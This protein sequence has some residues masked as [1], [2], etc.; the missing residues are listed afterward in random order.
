MASLKEGTTGSRT[1]PLIN[2]CWEYIKNSVNR[3]QFFWFLEY[4]LFTLYIFITYQ[5]TCSKPGFRIRH[6]LTGGSGS[7]RSPE[8]ASKF[9]MSKREIITTLLLIVFRNQRENYIK[10]RKLCNRT[11]LFFIIG[12]IRKPVLNFYFSQNL[13]P[14]SYM[15]WV[16]IFL[17]ICSEPLFLWIHFFVD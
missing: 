10:T 1:F 12:R 9:K 14:V 15:F 4:K 5:L 13:T 2:F 8:N 11:R 3:L 16:P 7:F 6:I 17:C